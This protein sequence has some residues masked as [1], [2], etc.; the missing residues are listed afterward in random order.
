MT[1]VYSDSD[2]GIGVPIPVN[3]DI[4]FTY[5]EPYKFEDGMFMSFGATASAYINLTIPYTDPFYVGRKVGYSFGI[6]NIPSYVVVGWTSMIEEGWSA[7]DKVKIY[8]S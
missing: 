8:F 7:F 5:E 1:V 3:F 2:L 4:E 6:E